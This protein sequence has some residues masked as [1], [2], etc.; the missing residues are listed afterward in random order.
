[1]EHILDF[2]YYIHVKFLFFISIFPVF[3]EY[4]SMTRLFKNKNKKGAFK[5]ITSDSMKYNS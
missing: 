1:M 3:E 2:K 5:A 4:Y